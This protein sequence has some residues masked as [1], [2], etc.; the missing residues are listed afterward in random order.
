MRAYHLS[1]FSLIPGKTSRL[2][3]YQG[4]RTT[5]AVSAEYYESPKWNQK[6]PRIQICTVTE[7]L[8]GAKIDMPPQ[9]GTFKQAPRVRD[10]EGQQAELEF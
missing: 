3:A 6:Y 7:L 4:K 8:K 9:H 5:E 1:I 2:I 10:N